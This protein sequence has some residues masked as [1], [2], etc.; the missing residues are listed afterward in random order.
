[1]GSAIG[2]CEEVVDELLTRGEK[3]GVLK[4]RLYRPSPPNTCCKLCRDPCATWRYWTE[5]KSLAPRQNR[6][7]WM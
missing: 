5:P 3:V 6:S 2:T 1:M 7:I 4:V